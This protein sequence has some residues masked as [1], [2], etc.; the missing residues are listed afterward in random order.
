MIN[1]EIELVFKWSQNCVLT[2][3]ATREAKP[4]RPAGDDPATQPALDT[5]AA[6]NVPPDLK[7]S[8]ADCKLFVPVI[9]LHAEYENKLYEQLKTGFTIIVAWKKI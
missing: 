6:I 2:S 4:A 3:K 5:V 7:F 8:I 1:C 9:I